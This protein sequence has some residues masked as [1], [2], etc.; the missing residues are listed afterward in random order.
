M[1]AIPLRPFAAVHR[2]RFGIHPRPRAALAAVLRRVVAPLRRVS[3]A[4]RH[5]LTFEQAMWL[6]IAALLVVFIV[7]LIFGATGVARG[8]R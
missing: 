2:D 8:G 6:V 3:L 5:P 7:V 4:L 1:T